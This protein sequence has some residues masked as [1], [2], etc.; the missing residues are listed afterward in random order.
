MK[1]RFVVFLLATLSFLSC[2]EGKKKDGEV[3]VYQVGIKKCADLASD[4]T[5]YEV[6]LDGPNPVNS[7]TEA[8][9]P[10]NL[11]QSKELDRAQ[12][13]LENYLTV[14]KQMLVLGDN[15]AVLFPE[16]EKIQRGSQRAAK[17]LG[18]IYALRNWGLDGSVPNPVQSS[19]VDSAE[20]EARLKRMG[21]TLREGTAMG[22]SQDV[23]ANAGAI[24]AAARKI[25][26]AKLLHLKKG[27]DQAV[28]DNQRMQSL[29]KRNDYWN[30]EGMKTFTDSARS[31]SGIY[32]RISKTLQQELRHRKTAS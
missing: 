19:E 16:K 11:K 14:A 29:A 23:M 7:T 5:A 26:T 31:L 9:L 30:T 17:Y 1:I 8:Q 4:L 25:P 12:T 32:Y 20:F 2:Q 10:A 18:Q 24:T 27:Y 15:K 22:I 28:D 6:I 3:A 13:L 21:Q